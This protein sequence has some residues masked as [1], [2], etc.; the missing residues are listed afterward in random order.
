MTRAPRPHPHR[1]VAHRLPAPGHGAHRAVLVGL[2]APLRRRLHPAHRR[3]RRRA[4]DAGGGRPDHRRD[5]LAGS[6]RTTKARSS[7]CSASSAT[8][9]SSRRCW[10]PAR[11]T[12]A[13]A[14]PK[15]ST[16]CAR[17]SAR[18][19]RSR[20]TTAAGGP[21]QASGCHAAARRAAGGA[22]SQPAG[23]RGQLARPGQG[24]DQRSPTASSTTWSLPAPMRDA[25]WRGHAHLQLLRGRRRLGHAASATSSAATTMSTTRR[26]RSTSCARSGADAAGV[27]PCADDPRRRRRQ[28]VQAPRR[29]QRD[30]VRGRRLPARGDAQLPGAPGLEPRRRRAVQPRA[31]GAPGSMASHLATQPRA[32]GPG[33]AELGQCALPEA[34][35]RCVAGRAGGARSWRGAASR[36]PW[37]SSWPGAALCSRTAARP[38]SSWPTGSACI[39]CEVQPSAD[40][41]AA[42]VTDAVRPALRGTARPAGRCGLGQGI[43]RRGASRTRCRSTA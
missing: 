11:P 5:A 25:Q 41:L 37:T 39:S 28:A 27:R 3:H 1:A 29:G 18:A 14:R 34:A 7:R 12:A 26:G 20:A 16:R 33:Q 22:L 21:S 15:S 17:R 19:A 23:R 8:A 42:H 31:A 30:A 4:L 9:R 2:C 6:G 32:V 13:S 35:R 40:E 24:P 10:P 43:D 36:P 38:R